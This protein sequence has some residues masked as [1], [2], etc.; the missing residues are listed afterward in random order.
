MTAPIAKGDALTA[1]RAAAFR[2]DDLDASDYGRVIVHSFLGW[3][4]AD[5]D[6]DA[7][8]RLIQSSDDVRWDDGHL[9]SH[10]VRVV[11]PEGRVYHFQGKRS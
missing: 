1:V 7:V 11:S 3:C 9:L 8:E 5:W 4:G 6:L 2:I 10:P